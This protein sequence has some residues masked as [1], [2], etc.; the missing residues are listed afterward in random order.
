MDEDTFLKAAEEV[1]EKK[2]NREYSEGAAKQLSQFMERYTGDIIEE[3]IALSEDG[4][5]TKETVVSSVSQEED[6]Q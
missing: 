6:D 5:L 4:Q 3:A 1:L 2:T